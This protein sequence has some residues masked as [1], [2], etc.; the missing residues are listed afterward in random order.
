MLFSW[1][2]SSP[3]RIKSGLW[4]KIHSIFTSG[5]W[6][7]PPRSLR[8]FLTRG[9]RFSRHALHETT[10]PVLYPTAQCSAIRQSVSACRTMLVCVCVPTTHDNGEKENQ[11]RTGGTGQ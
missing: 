1:L 4:W 6:S 3:Y 10:L 8:N 9:S 2:P 5:Y 11:R 7:T